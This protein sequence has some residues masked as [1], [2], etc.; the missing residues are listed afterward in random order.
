MIPHL[1]THFSSNNTTRSPSHMLISRCARRSAQLLGVLTAVAVL[2][3]LALS[4]A[5][6]CKENWRVADGLADEQVAPNVF[7]EHVRIGVSET[8]VTLRQQAN[9]TGRW[10]STE[11]CY[12]TFLDLYDHPST[13]LDL[14][15]GQQL[16]LNDV[17]NVDREWTAAKLGIPERLGVPTVWHKQ[18]GVMQWLQPICQICA[19]FG[20]FAVGFKAFCLVTGD[21]FE[22]ESGPVVVA[23]FSVVPAVLHV[24]PTL[25]W[26]H[27]LTNSNLEVG[28]SLTLAIVATATFVWA[29]LF[30]VAVL[31]VVW[32][33]ARCGCVRLEEDI[34]TQV[35]AVAARCLPKHKG[36]QQE[37]AQHLLGQPRDQRD[38]DARQAPP[39]RQ[40]H[41]QTRGK[42]KGDR[43]HDQSVQRTQDQRVRE[44]RAARAGASL[45]E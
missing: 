45:Q 44:K 41:E 32:S 11:T 15:T 12:R 10:R 26:A 1:T 19:W 40:R 33:Y 2:V 9:A 39:R 35:V 8:C 37:E 20:A 6:L 42:S 7:F 34:E 31:F 5:S 36:K 17:C 23:V 43:P 28:V 38:Q 16:I 27:W 18:C 4:I 25:L 14:E 13:T 30:I 24:I 22:P 29:W 3:G 21:E